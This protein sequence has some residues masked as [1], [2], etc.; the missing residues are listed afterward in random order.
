MSIQDGGQQN[1]PL[2]VHRA[3]PLVMLGAGVVGAHPKDGHKIVP[4]DK[5]RGALPAH[6]RRSLTES[7]ADDSE[8]SVS[9]YL[10]N[11]AQMVYAII[12]ENSLYC[13]NRSQSRPGGVR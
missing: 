12:A 3:P 2:T 4:E 13:R 5:I 11:C 6:S 10:D 7:I 8:K 1:P 9:R